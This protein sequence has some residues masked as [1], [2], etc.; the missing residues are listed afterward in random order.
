MS[1]VRTVAI[2]LDAPGL[3]LLMKNPR[4]VKIG[5]CMY[6]GVAHRTS[7]RRQEDLELQC[8]IQGAIRNSKQKHNIIK[9]SFVMCGLLDTYEL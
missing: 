8:L 6:L 9:L 2:A 5:K 7:G 1:V 3:D 4:A